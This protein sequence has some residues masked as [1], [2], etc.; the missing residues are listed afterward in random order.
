MPADAEVH[1]KMLAFLHTFQRERGAPTNMYVTV[2]EDG[3]GGRDLA[4]AI[5]LPV[6]RIEGLFLNYKACA[7]DAMVRPGDRVAFVPYGTPAS[8][9][10]FLGPFRARG[11]R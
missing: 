7:L 3:V 9:P 5:G 10:A 8:H 2:P 4:L 1:V 6:E 11:Q